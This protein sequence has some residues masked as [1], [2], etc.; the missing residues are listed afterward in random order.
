MTS[1]LC[2]FWI[3]KNNGV[4]SYL[5]ALALRSAPFFTS[6]FTISSLPEG[7]ANSGGVQ[8][9]LSFALTSAPLEISSSTA[10]LWPLWAAQCRGVHVSL[11]R[12]LTSAPFES[13]ELSIRTSPVLAAQ[14]SG[15]VIGAG[16]FLQPA[17]IIVNAEIRQ[18]NPLSLT[19]VPQTGTLSQDPRRYKAQEA[20]K[21]TIFIKLAKFPA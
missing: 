20:A 18:Q 7:K 11:S 21:V 5:P 16:F 15:V 8:P 2:S 1:S 10:S 17:E 13:S 4:S 14:C 19:L 6:S 3:A 12:T 9:S